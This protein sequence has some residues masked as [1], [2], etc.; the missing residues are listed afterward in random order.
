MSSSITPAIAVA[1]L[2]SLSSFLIKTSLAYGCCWLLARCATSAT[3][4]FTIW[5]LYL[6]GTTGFW[7]YSLATFLQVPTLSK[8][9]TAAPAPS[10]LGV[11]WVVPTNFTRDI[12]DLAAALVAFYA[13]ALLITAGLGLWRRLHLYR[14][15]RFRI[16]PPEQIVELFD[17]ITCDMHLAQ[18]DLWVLPGLTSP[19]TLGSIHS[20]VYLPTD[21]EEQ[22]AIELGA[23]LR[24]ELKHVKRKDSLWE[25][26]SRGCRFLLCFHPLVHRAFAA[27]RF[28]REVACD[29]AVVR[30]CPERRDV[31]AETLVRFG[32]K[33]A[34]ADEPDYIGIGFTSAAAILNARVRW[35]LTGEE[36]YS[37]WSRKGRAVASAGILWIFL[38]ATPALWVAFSLAPLPKSIVI[39]NLQQQT[40]RAVS[41]HTLFRAEPRIA[42]PTVS[43]PTASVSPEPALSYTAPK[44][45]H[46]HIQNVDEPMSNPVESDDSL[47]DN[48]IRRQGAA[49]GSA[50]TPHAKGPSATSVIVDT[51][52]QLGRMG[53]GDHD[54]GHD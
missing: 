32:W 18:C 3:R 29:M 43:A 30:S 44:V 5:F 39:T 38:A 28:E 47:A 21:C 35:I 19:A 12:V 9:A 54:H 13:A 25:A 6:V 16:T 40:Y 53:L 23:V 41:H 45:P 27:T 8:P 51:A 48:A 36:I 31:Y 4:R 42:A 17:E 52:S 10:R 33:A 26:I 2:C 46:Y 50:A 15:L 34:V 37:A 49:S 20:A 22:D 14:A 11:S 7:I 1:L 24:H